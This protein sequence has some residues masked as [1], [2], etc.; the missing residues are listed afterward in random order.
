MKW[1]ILL[2]LV[3]VFLA[4]AVLVRYAVFHV[5]EEAVASWDLTSL[6]LDMMR[7]SSATVF[8]P[9]TS[10]LQ[11]DPTQDSSIAVSPLTTP[12]PTQN[13]LPTPD[14]W[15]GGSRVTVLVM[16]LDYGD[17]ENPERAGPPRT[18]SMMLLTIDPIAQTAGMLSIPR[19]LYVNVPGFGSRKINVAYRFG[20]LYELPGGGPELAMRTVEGFLGV[21]IDFYAQI[22]FYAFEEFIDEIGGVS[23]AVPEEIKVDPIGPGNTVILKPGRQ[24]LE[25]P[26]AL[27]Y[28]RARYTEGG[29]FDR[30]KRQQQVIM[31][32]RDKVMSVEML[33]RLVMRAPQLYASLNDGIHTDMSLEQAIKLAWLVQ[34]IEEKDIVRGAMSP[35]EAMPARSPTGEAI[36]QPNPIRIRELRDKVFSTEISS[37]SEWDVQDLLDGENAKIQLLNGAGNDEVGTAAQEYLL[38]Q[39]VPGV[40]SFETADSVSNFTK[41]TDFTGNPYT[42]KYLV[43]LLEID[44]RYI[45]SRY[46][47]N[48]QVDIEL[49]LGV[50]WS[51][52]SQE[53]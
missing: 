43:E 30:A 21:P 6:G 9:N 22:D 29:D 32:V 36:L 17:W 16:G 8:V 3:V 41:I 1:G 34:G 48:S 40:G 42:V 44:P 12:A 31:A 45:A 5:T 39:G 37:L 4:S 25:G 19:D 33:P 24:T 23:I 11:R 20:E 10:E 15:D 7:S 14:P 35:N 47:P 27:A 26:V 50:D 46:D 28:A 2:L 53:P 51:R 49:V 38:S 18:D 52:K 13:P